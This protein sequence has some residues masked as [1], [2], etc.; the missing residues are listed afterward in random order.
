[1]KAKLKKAPEP[2]KAVFVHSRQIEREMSE[3]LSL[4]E[5]VAQAEIAA[6][7]SDR[8]ERARRGLRLAHHAKMA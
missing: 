6:H 8:E 3:L 4:R 1:M 2:H 5:Q 7:R